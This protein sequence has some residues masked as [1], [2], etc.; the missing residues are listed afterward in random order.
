MRETP[1]PQFFIDHRES[2]YILN[3]GNT[4]QVKTGVLKTLGVLEVGKQYCP[5]YEKS[6]LT[7]LPLEHPC[8]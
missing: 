8:G 1:M 2:G 5:D 6:S 3:A 4:Q 7:P